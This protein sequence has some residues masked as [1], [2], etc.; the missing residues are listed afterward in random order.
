MLNFFKKKDAPRETAMFTDE[1]LESERVYQ[2]GLSRFQD[3]IAP[4]AIKIAPRYIRV[5]ETLAQTIFVMTY[6][7]YLHSNWFSP[8]INFDISMDISM[9]IHPVETY[10]ILKTLRKTATQVES[11]YNM[12]R[13]SGLVR[14]PALET[15]SKTSK[16]SGISSNREQKNSSSSDFI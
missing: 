2:E 3:L 11:R 16:N 14:D 15:A 1:V 4:P 9:F 12:E 10:E 6:P 7:R 8:I 5:G 13:N